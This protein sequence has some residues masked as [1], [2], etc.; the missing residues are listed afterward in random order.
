MDFTTGSPNEEALSQLIESL[1]MFI[2]REGLFIESLTVPEAEE[3]VSGQ[4]AVACFIDPMIYP[5][6]A[7]VRKSQVENG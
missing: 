5:N 7:S 1:I 2:I 4:E 3:T 6:A